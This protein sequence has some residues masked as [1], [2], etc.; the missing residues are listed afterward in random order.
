[1][2]KLLILMNPF[3]FFDKDPS[4]I[5]HL[6]PCDAKNFLCLD[7]VKLKVGEDKEETLNSI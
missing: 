1:M 6:I 3:Y 7:Q 4:P 5:I 2:E